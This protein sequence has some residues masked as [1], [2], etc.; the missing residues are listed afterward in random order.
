MELPSEASPT[1]SGGTPKNPQI[2]DPENFWVCRNCDSS[3]AIWICSYFQPPAITTGSRP[4]RTACRNRF[5]IVS[6]S[7]AVIVLIASLIRSPEGWP[8]SSKNRLPNSSALCDCWI[9]DWA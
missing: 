2:A 4:P 1:S 8:P 5:L 7:S 6:D 3:G 9:M